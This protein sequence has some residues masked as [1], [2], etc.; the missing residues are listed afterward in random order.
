MPRRQR[1]VLFPRV[2]VHGRTIRLAT[3]IV[4]RE[5]RPQNVQLKVEQ[6]RTIELRK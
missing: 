4:E 3:W 2:K 1:T 6:E 5:A